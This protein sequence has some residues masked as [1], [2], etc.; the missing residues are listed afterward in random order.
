[1]R[2][3]GVG[4]KGEY[5]VAYAWRATAILV[6]L[7]LVVM[8]TEGM[9]VPSLPT[10]QRDMNISAA[11]ASWILSIYILMGTLSSAIMGKLGD[12]YGKKRMLMITMITYTIGALITG[13]STSYGMLLVGRA[14]QGVGM[15]MMPLAFALVREEFPPRMI[16]QVQGLISAMFGVGMAV[17]LPLG[18]YVSQT[19]GWQA[20]YHTVY[21]F[22]ILE[23]LMVY[24]YI[25]ESRVRNPQPIDW[26]GLFLLSV[27]LASGLIAVTD[28]PTY[29]WTDPLI[30]LLLT[31]FV[32]GFGVFILYETT[33]DHPLVP[34]SLLGNSNVMAANIGVALAGF[35]LF[36]MAQALT[37]LLESPKPLGYDLSILDTGIMMIPMAVVQMIVAPIAGR[38]ITSIGARKLAVIGSSIAIIGLLMLTY[39]SFYGLSYVIG[40]MSVLSAGISMVN[41]AVINIL[42]FSVGRRNMGLATGLNSVFRNIGGAWGPAVAGSLMSMYQASVLI[43]LKP[44]FWITLPAKF[45]YQLM[46]IITTA[47]YV[48]AIVVIVA[49]TREIFVKGE[50][51]ALET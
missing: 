44:L 13:F 11:D 22:I 37:Y 2:G 45:S 40:S 18:A 4:L 3:G 31:L 17:S 27:S 35:A 46:F 36:L 12:M 9:L 48:M 33:V 10:I 16:P 8:Y 25:R 23:D 1:M 39:T 5:D 41:V 19:L 30:I 43:S 20:T 34:I 26:I 24:L 14:L 6:T 7:T 28:A 51:R 29:G 47:L 32:L 49:L 50:I 38:V 42:V 15:A 21:P